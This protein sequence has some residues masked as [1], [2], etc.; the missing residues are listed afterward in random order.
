MKKPKS[1]KKFKK[2]ILAMEHRERF[3][4][5][6]NQK[7]YLE[8]YCTIKFS[9]RNNPVNYSFKAW[10]R[11]DLKPVNKTKANLDDYYLNK[12]YNLIE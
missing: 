4:F 8:I 10:N 5:K 12:I 11:E 7:D 9:S 3:V 2:T 6:F 1:L